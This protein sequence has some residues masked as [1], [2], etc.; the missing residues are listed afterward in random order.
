M[1][2]KAFNQSKKSFRIK[3]TAVSVVAVAV[4]FS[5]LLTP[6][7]ARAFSLGDVFGGIG[8]VI[9]IG[10][11]TSN[12]IN[13]LGSG[14]EAIF[15]QKMNLQA[16][17]QPTMEQF[18]KQKDAEWGGDGLFMNLVKNR[19]DALKEY[20]SPS[21]YQQ[22]NYGFQQTGDYS[23]LAR[24]AAATSDFLADSAE[25]KAEYTAG[26]Q[27]I[28]GKTDSGLANLFAGEKKGED[29][30]SDITG[31]DT[32]IES[33]AITGFMNQEGGGGLGDILGGIIGSFI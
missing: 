30:V 33:G 32:A 16:L 23:L 7:K 20:I 8:A 6:A 17:Y 22:Q 3:K 12:L 28:E 1:R 4:V 14:F 13:G 25:A 29:L 9:G 10:N 26:Q 15:N 31:I 5:L 11:S 2:N 27:I 24:N 18:V 21:T 19:G